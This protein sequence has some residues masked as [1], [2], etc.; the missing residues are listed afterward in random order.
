MTTRDAYREEIG[1]LGNPRGPA[2]DDARHRRAMAVAV[3]TR[4]EQADEEFGHLDGASPE[5]RVGPPDAG[6]QHV[7]VHPRAKAGELV[8]VVERP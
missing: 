3:V 1:A 6:V 5:L 2:S 8:L 4:A 7:D